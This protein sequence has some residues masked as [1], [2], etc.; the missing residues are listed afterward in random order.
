VARPESSKGVGNLSKLPTPF[1]DSGR[2]T[3]QTGVRAAAGPW[4]EQA[5]YVVG[6]TCGTILA[7][8]V[9]FV[10]KKP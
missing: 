5:S 6:A 8:I 7:M 9:P 1:E 2:A 4:P 3:Q 10:R